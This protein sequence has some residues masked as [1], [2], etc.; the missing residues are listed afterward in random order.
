MAVI[1]A[2]RLND[3]LTGTTESDSITGSAGGDL[4]QGGPGADTV[5]SGTGNLSPDGKDTLYGGQGDDSLTGTSGGRLFG[6]AGAD[7]IATNSDAAFLVEGGAG[8]DLLQGSP[9]G[10]ASA[11]YIHA[12]SGVQVDLTLGGPQTVGG[13]QGT[14]TLV[15]IDG[16]FGSDFG[17]TLTGGLARDALVGGPGDDRLQGGSGVDNLF[18]G[19]GNDT[20][21]GGDGIDGVYYIAPAAG[22]AGPS[23]G[24]T[25]DLRISGSQAIGGGMGVDTLVAIENAGGDDFA[26]TLTGSTGDNVLNGGEG[27]DSLSGL[28]GDDT[29]IGE[30]GD[31]VLLGGDGNDDLLDAAGRNFVR[32]EGGD[33]S[34]FG[35]GQF[36]DLHGNAG[37]DTLRG[38]DG[39][40]W[41]RGGQGDDTLDGRA[42]DDFISGDRGADTM[43]GRDGADIFNTFADAGVDRVLDFSRA[44]GDR[45]RVEGG[46]AWAV[47][48]QGGDVVVDVT[49]G[50]RMVLAGVQLSSLTGDWIF[51]A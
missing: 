12:T 33:D 45:V 34:I 25:V 21:L 30:G 18:P 41:V 35:G 20:V 8:D 17:D 51:A 43:A 31:D 37:A 28:A 42:G 40:D 47:S 26:D 14:D 38:F 2:A 1:G 15:R 49:G 46:S 36:D 50:A 11:L 19:A 6:D 7:T 24:V 29:L 44:E 5:N 4:I 16:V 48:Q 3:T 23:G 27:G 39:D 13:G 9:G 32:G 10:G 22:F